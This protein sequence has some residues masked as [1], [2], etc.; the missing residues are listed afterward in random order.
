MSILFHFL[1]FFLNHH[2]EPY[3]SILQIKGFHSCSIV[4]DKSLLQNQ[5]PY[6]VDPTGSLGFIFAV[7]FHF[8]QFKFLSNLVQISIF[9]HFQLLPSLLK[10]NQIPFGHSTGYCQS[11]LAQDQKNFTFWSRSLLSGPKRGPG[12]SFW[13]DRCDQVAHFSPKGPI[14]SHKSSFFCLYILSD[15]LAYFG[16]IWRP[17]CHI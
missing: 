16:K 4:R 13:R 17:H 8:P 11:D 15:P 3:P 6:Q 14:L 1:S 12:H 5:R 9:L 2:Q 7:Y 10:A